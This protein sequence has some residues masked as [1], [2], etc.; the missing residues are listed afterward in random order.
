MTKHAC[1]KCFDQQHGRCDTARSL[2]V[3][4]VLYSI[5]KFQFFLTH[6]V[7]LHVSLESVVAEQNHFVKPPSKPCSSVRSL[8]LQC[9][10]TFNNHA[11][12][13]AAMACTA[14]PS[15]LA[16]SLP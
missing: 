2:H 5:V 11:K 3:A 10:H 4:H 15:L 7:A 14:Q 6:T 1:N 16:Q 13:V 12:L 8:A 9:D